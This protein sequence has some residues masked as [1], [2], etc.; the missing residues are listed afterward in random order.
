MSLFDNSDFEYKVFEDTVPLDVLLELCKK[1]KVD[2]KDIFISDI[3][4]KFTEYVASLEVKNYDNISSFVLLASTLLEYKSS[5]L[6]PKIEFAGENEDIPSQ[7]LFLMRLEEYKILKEAGEK[8]S[9]R[10]LL[11][12]FYR[13]PE[14]GEGEYKL[15]IKNFDLNKMIAAFSRL[16]ERVEFAEDPDVPK[17]I[18][19]E[20]F[21][22]ADRVIELVEAIRAYKVLNFLSLFEPDF[23]KIEKINTFL[24]LLEILKRQIAVCEQSEIAGDITIRYTPLT[25]DF[26]GSGEELLTDANRYN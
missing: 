3:T 5:S 25:D 11:N 17:T 21:T 1:G 15:V 23:S 2:I 8:L 24:A 19:K 12:R 18:M 13:V 7:D 22:V 14:F 20:R 4:Q 16:M 9:E 6:L 26:D 10:E